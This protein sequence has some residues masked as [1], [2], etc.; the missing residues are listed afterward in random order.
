MRSLAIQ[1][2]GTIELR[3]E[4]GELGDVLFLDVEIPYGNSTRMVRDGFVGVA[5]ADAVARE[6]RRLQNLT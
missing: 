5:G 4:P 2:I 1:N 3:S 6:M